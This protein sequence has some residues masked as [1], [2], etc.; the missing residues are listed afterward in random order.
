MWMCYPDHRQLWVSKSSCTFKMGDKE[1]GMAELSDERGEGKKEDILLWPLEALTPMTD[2]DL[3]FLPVSCM[4][5]IH[6]ALTHFS[7]FLFQNWIWVLLS[8][9]I[10]LPVKYGNVVVIDKKS[11]KNSHMFK[12]F[13]AGKIM[14]EEKGELLW[15]M[16]SQVVL[17]VKNPPAN[18]GD[19]RDMGS[20]PGLGRFPRED[21]AT[22]SSIL[23]WKIPWTEE[24]GRLQSIWSQ[25]A[26]HDWSDLACSMAP[27]TMSLE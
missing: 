9:E 15:S 22:H 24:P 8:W 17:E 11:R 5:C 14:T 26:G 27:L 23:T 20:I 13:L 12:V 7:P 3:D 16:A 21:V 19:I 4:G 2:C 6:V 18:T 25:R 1:V 10:D